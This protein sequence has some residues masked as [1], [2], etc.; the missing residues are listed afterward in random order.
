MYTRVHVC[1]Q[2]SLKQHF[3]FYSEYWAV[4]CDVCSGSS[5]PSEDGLPSPPMSSHSLA[6]EMLELTR[7][8]RR[9]D[10][11]IQTCTHN[12]QQM[13][14]EIHNK[15][16]PFCLFVLC[17]S[18]N[19][20]KVGSRSSSCLMFVLNCSHICLC[21]ISGHPKNKK[22]KGPNG[23]SGQSTFRDQAGSARPEGG[24]ALTLILHS[25]KQACGTQDIL[26]K[27][28]F[29]CP[30]LLTS[31]SYWASSVIMKR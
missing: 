29:C 25:R 7:E 12:V 21:N 31:P 24:N 6:R 3:N 22:L 5:L 9:L 11:L 19:A 13:T 28:S 14:E 8:E 16:Y 15:K 20:W 17:L 2:V 18:L 30:C 10:E 27:M 23:R 4:F 26:K 1:L